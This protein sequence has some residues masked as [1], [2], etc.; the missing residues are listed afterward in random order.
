M[1]FAMDYKSFFAGSKERY[2]YSKLSEA[3]KNN[4]EFILLKDITDF[5]WDY[6][7]AIYPYGAAE[8]YQKKRYEKLVGFEFNGEP[9]EGG[10]QD[11]NLRLLFV[12]KKHKNSVVINADRVIDHVITR[13]FCSQEDQKLTLK[14]GPDGSYK[15]S[16]RKGFYKF[17]HVFDLQSI[18]N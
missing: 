2:F 5:E 3:S 17:Y 9:P 8:E 6:V 10:N 18:N 14:I 4:K 7:C 12:S 1:L 13:E 16:Y 11:G 15:N